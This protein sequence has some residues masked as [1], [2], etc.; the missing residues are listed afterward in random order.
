MSAGGGYEASVIARRC[1]WVTLM[2][3]GAIYKS[4]VRPAILYGTEALCLNKNGMGM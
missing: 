3:C 2:E 1:A 4:Y